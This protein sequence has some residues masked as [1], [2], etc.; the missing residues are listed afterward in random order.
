MNVVKLG[1]VKLTGKIIRDGVLNLLLKTVEGRLW[2]LQPLIADTQRSLEYFEQ[3]RKRGQIH[4]RFFQNV[5]Y[6]EGIT[7][8]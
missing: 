4:G 5:F 1:K 7:V 8:A 2:N 6:V 3:E